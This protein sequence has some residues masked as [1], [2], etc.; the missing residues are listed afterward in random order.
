MPT[1]EFDFQT[2]LQDNLENGV[3]VYPSRLPQDVTL[4]AVMYRRISGQRIRSIDG[5][6]GLAKPRFELNAYAESYVEAK[7]LA[8]EMRTLFDGFRG[9][10][11]AG[12]LVEN[13]VFDNDQDT[14]DDD[15]GLERV[16]IDVGVWHQEN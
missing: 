6:T 11:G 4:P 12:T 7:N 15:T 5:A 9:V 10:I 13:I 14:F 2:F 8:N 16:I 3:K 1:I